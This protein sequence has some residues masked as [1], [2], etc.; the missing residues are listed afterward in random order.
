MGHESKVLRRAEDTFNRKKNHPILRQAR[1]EC[2]MTKITVPTTY[3]VEVYVYTPKKLENNKRNACLIHAH[4]GG[5]VGL[6]AAD[7]KNWRANF[8]V[9]CGVV[10][11]DVECLV[12]HFCS[13]TFLRNY[14]TW[15]FSTVCVVERDCGS[16]IKLQFFK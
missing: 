14:W 13:F 15:T 8:A 3:D 12:K 2:I 5:A 9:K 11:F 6:S 1:D 7:V 16:A 10:L 4:G